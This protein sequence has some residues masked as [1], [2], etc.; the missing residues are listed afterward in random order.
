MAVSGH[1]IL[2]IFRAKNQASATIRKVAKDVNFLGRTVQA[3]QRGAGTMRMGRRA[4]GLGAAMTHIGGAATL[5]GGGALFG[6]GTAARGFAEFDKLATQAATQIGSI[7]NST[8]DVIQNASRLRNAVLSE[9]QTFPDSAEVMSQAAYDIFSSMDVNF[10]KGI[11]LLHLFNQAGVAGMTDVA[12]ATDG[13]ITV[14]NNFG[15]PNGPIGKSRDLL[16]D[17]FSIIRFGRIDLETLNTMM[18][19]IAPAAAAADACRQEP[20]AGIAQDLH[21]RGNVSDRD[22]VVD[23]LPG[24]AGRVPARHVRRADLQL[25]RGGDPVT[26]HQAIGL[27]LL[28]VLMEVDEAWGDHMAGRVDHPGSLER[29]LRD[30]FDGAP[31]DAD[32]ANA[33]EPRLRI[34]DAPAGNHQ[35]EPRLRW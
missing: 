10:N 6:L 32:V 9:M 26:H 35:V 16:N 3:N 30:R 28:T 24:L 27:L 23:D 13:A 5:A 21:P 11:G 33:V 19:Q 20:C 7:N 4:A 18:N 29:R 15:N 22:A 8:N 14:L 31:A 17:M 34:H 1:E 2:L 25:E 12:T